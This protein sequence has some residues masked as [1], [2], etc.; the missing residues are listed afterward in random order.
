MESFHPSAAPP[1]STPTSYFNTWN[2]KVASTAPKNRAPESERALINLHI[3]ANGSI[4]LL[5]WPQDA[6]VNYGV[7]CAH[8]P[9]QIFTEWVKELLRRTNS[10]ADATAIR[11]QYRVTHPLTTAINTPNT[12]YA[13]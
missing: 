5:S 4:A 1:A 13:G 6:Y 12:M 10:F 9:P 7:L 11:N 2:M 8:S 3:L